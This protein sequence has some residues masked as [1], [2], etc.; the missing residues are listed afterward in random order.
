MPERTHRQYAVAPPLAHLT[1]DAG[2]AQAIGLYNAGQAPQAEALCAQLTQR[3]GS[4]PAV[5]QLQAVLCQERGDA[6]AGRVLIAASLRARPD[7][8]PS[9][10][11]AALL[12]QDL[13]D[14]QGAA[15]ALER[16]IRLQP[17]HVAAHLNLGIVRLE[18]G[19]RDA[20][21][22]HLGR[23]WRLRPETFGRIAGALCSERSGAVW[24]SADALRAAL[25]AAADL[26][27][28]A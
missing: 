20:A 7:H 5:L 23:A 6:S 8:V 25:N 1:L 27:P 26:K 2:L 13:Q 4:H 12:C 19:R 15:A 3:F 17:T 24:L 11:V 28:G 18:Q 16:V 14:L 9:L 22:H 21:L 10:M